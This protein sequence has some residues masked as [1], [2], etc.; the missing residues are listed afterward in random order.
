MKTILCYGDS[1]TYGLKS[2][3]Q[4]R[5]PREVRWT[6]ILQ[7][8]LGEEYYVIEE[9]LGGRTTVWDDPV[10]D[11]KNGKKYLLPCLDSHK[12]LDLV[13]IML[14]TNDLKTRF[15]VSAFDVSVAMENLV[16]TILKSD[17]GID[18]QAPQVLLVTPVPI[19]SVNNPD[20]DQ[21][22][23]GAEEKS[24]MLAPYYEEIAKRN[25]IHY[26]NPEGMIEVN[27]VDG[28]HY[29]EKGHRQMAEMMVEKIREIGI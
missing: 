22:L 20:L 15:S 28:I 3:L 24:K 10:E 21:M 14:G 11:Y 7:K 5:Y 1:N 9:G 17:A 23:A 12:P 27:D 2:D 13:I 6:G 25:Q 8:M 19:H 4:T 16:K 29:T 26:L 18:F